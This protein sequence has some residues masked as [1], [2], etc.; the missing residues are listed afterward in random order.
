MLN[1][2]DLNTRGILQQ[3]ANTSDGQ[4]G[5][6]VAWT[7]VATLWA[8]VRAVQGT[9]G[10]AADQQRPMVTY[11]ITIRFRP[12]LT[13]SQY[14]ADASMRF[15]VGPRTFD[16]RSVIDTDETHEELVLGCELYAP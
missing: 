16:I 9:E 1:A 7:D 2:G 14:G 6:L 5:Q 10:L 11:N 8:K 4:G 12:G 3:R 15:V 13:P